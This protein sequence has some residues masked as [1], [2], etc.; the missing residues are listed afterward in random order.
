V[1]T[2]GVYDL[3][4]GTWQALAK[5]RLIVRGERVEGITERGTRI[6]GS[7]RRDKQTARLVFEVDVHIPPN[8]ETVVGIEAGPEGRTMHIKGELPSEGQERRFSVGL[9]GRAI[10]ISMRYVGPLPEGGIPGA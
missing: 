3:V 4:L 10:D 2:D 7:C 1:Q 8:V 9:G 6:V 5:A